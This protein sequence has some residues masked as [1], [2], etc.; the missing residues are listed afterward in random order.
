VH[1]TFA[2]PSASH[3]FKDDTTQTLP[4]NGFVLRSDCFNPGHYLDLPLETRVYVD[5]TCVHCADV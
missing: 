3:D 5:I 4:S 2:S 1:Q